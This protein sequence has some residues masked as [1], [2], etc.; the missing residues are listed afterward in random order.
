MNSEE[1]HQKI[2]EMVVKSAAYAK[3][4][5]EEWYE[6]IPLELAKTEMQFSNQVCH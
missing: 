5:N 3:K 4:L 1:L 6:D 2:R